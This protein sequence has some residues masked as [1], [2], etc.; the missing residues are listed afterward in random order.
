MAIGSGRGNVAVILCLLKLVS[1]WLLG[2]PAPNGDDDD[3]NGDARMGIAAR[4]GSG[5]K[6][7]SGWKGMCWG[8]CCFG[9]RGG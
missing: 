1:L 4:C 6:G 3:Q 5:K 7:I 9:P 2:Y 8:L